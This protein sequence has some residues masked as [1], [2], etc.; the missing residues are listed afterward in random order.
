MLLSRASFSHIAHDL[1]TTI[2]PQRA[3]FD[4]QAAAAQAL[5]GI[6]VEQNAPKVLPTQTLVMVVHT[7]QHDEAGNVFWSV[8]VVRWVVFHPEPNQNVDT[9]V[10]AKT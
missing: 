4:P 3:A 1:D 5:H 10:P 7:E 8:R 9:L 6:E 2:A